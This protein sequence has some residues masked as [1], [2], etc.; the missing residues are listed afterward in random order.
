MK[1]KQK[2][3]WCFHTTAFVLAVQ[4]AFVITYEKL[5]FDLFHSF[6]D[7][8]NNDD[9]GCTTEWNIRPKHTIKDEWDHAHNDKTYCTYKYNII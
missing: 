6:E 5:W 3:L 8:T 4:K 7:N 9:D 1:Q 2:R